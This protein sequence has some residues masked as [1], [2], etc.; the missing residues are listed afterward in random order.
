MFEF[1]GW[2][3]LDPA[4]VSI[5]RL[6]AAI[7]AHSNAPSG[8][9]SEWTNGLLV[10]FVSNGSHF[11]H[12][13]RVWNR[14]EVGEAAVGQLWKTLRTLDAR[15]KGR[16][17]TMDHDRVDSPDFAQTWW[18]DGARMKVEPSNLSGTRASRWYG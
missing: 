14:R 7:A 17:E 15:L 6:S 18:F 1:H 5:T 9:E 3:E 8:T 10:G 13:A 2:F 11:V 4:Q 12:A 16:G